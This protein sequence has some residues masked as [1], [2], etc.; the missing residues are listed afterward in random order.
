MNGLCRASH[1]CRSWWW[2]HQEQLQQRQQSGD[3]SY[4][5]SYKASASYKA[6]FH[7]VMEIGFLVMYFQQICDKTIWMPCGLGDFN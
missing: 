1:G 2:Q 6:Y 3:A 7:K 4:K 5:A